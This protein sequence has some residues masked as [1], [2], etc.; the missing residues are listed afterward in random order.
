MRLH[1]VF[2]IAVGRQPDEGISLLMLNKIGIDAQQHLRV[3]D[4][5]RFNNVHFP[6]VVIPHRIH[7]CALERQ[8]DPAPFLV[9]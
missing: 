4:T 8:R 3:T 7:Y 2:G 1:E 5:G 9:S 6:D